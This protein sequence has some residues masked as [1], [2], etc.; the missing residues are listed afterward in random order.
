MDHGGSLAA[1]TQPATIHAANAMH[2]SRVV[3]MRVPFGSKL[4]GAILPRM[5]RMR[6]V[7]L[8]QGS[9]K[10]SGERLVHHERSLGAP[11]RF[12]GYR[13]QVR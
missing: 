3:L 11:V 6:L 12:T 7:S 9:T 1:E 8:K 13:I 2:V 4:P 5:D 10:R